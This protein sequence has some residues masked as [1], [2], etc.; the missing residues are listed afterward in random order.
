[1][2]LGR[3]TWL[4]GMPL[5]AVMGNS[6]NLLC[7]LGTLTIPCSPSSPLAPGSCVL[8]LVGQPLS[9]S[10]FTP[11]TCCQPHLTSCPSCPCSPPLR[12]PCPLGIPRSSK[13]SCCFH[14][15]SSWLGKYL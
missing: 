1:M 8:I 11:L 9:L 4:Y 14:V 15:H 7:L 3:P 10:R 13:P 6:S 2:G 12:G 5:G